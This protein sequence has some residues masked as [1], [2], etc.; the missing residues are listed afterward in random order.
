MTNI[1]TQASSSVDISSEVGEQPRISV[2]DVVEAATDGFSALIEMLL[3][4]RERARQR[5][6]LLSLGD[7]ALKDF[8][9]N[10]ADAVGEGDKP[11]WRA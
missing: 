3:D 5:R 2:R 9:A 4:W 7:R 6:E 11:F 1:D 8:G 10:R